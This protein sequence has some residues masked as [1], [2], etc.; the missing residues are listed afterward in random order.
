MEIPSLELKENLFDI[1]N[2]Y[3]HIL[4]HMVTQ[5]RRL[6]GLLSLNRYSD[7]DRGIRGRHGSLTPVGS[8]GELVYTPLSYPRRADS[9]R[10]QGKCINRV[11]R[12]VLAVS[13]PKKSKR[14]RQ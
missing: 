9:G 13:R 14:H 11:K 10:C 1:A 2:K 5:P 3:D 4:L 7:R 12:E 8:E 6:L